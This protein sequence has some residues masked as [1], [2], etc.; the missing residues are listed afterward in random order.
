MPEDE[1]EGGATPPCRR[2]LGP[3]LKHNPFNWNPSPVLASC[4]LIRSSLPSNPSA[5]AHHSTF[6]CIYQH[7]LGILQGLLLYCTVYIYRTMQRLQG[8]TCR[9]KPYWRSSPMSAPRIH[10]PQAETQS[11]AGGGRRTCAEHPRSPVRLASRLAL[12]LA[13]GTLAV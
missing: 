4:S 10:L 9:F 11:Q 2:D 12:R 6:S 8:R 3:A 1:E 13:E 5:P 7:K